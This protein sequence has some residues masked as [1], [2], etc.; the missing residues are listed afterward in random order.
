MFMSVFDKNGL[1]ISGGH[2]WLVHV[3]VGLGV[4]SSFGQE[5]DMPTWCGCVARVRV[6]RTSGQ[7]AAEKLTLV[8]DAGTIIQPDAAASQ[9]EGC[10]LWGLS[11]AL[12]EGSEFVMGQPKDTNLDTYT[13]L[14]MGNVPEV[15]IEFMPSTE[16]PVGLGEPA[17][18][19]IAPAIANAIFAAT[20]ARLRHLPI[21]PQDVRQALAQRT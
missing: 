5:G 12:Y 1:P 17:T 3:D 11:M 16:T 15:D 20:G 14:R 8:V 10:A 21:R 2:F 4:A 18:A 7:V 9:V 19:V 13:I 6:D